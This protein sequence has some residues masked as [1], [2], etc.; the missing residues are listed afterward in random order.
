MKLPA[1]DNFNFLL[2]GQ[3]GTTAPQ[4]DINQTGRTSSTPALPSAGEGVAAAK[5]SL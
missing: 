3:L 2:Q 1:F 4:Y 5:E